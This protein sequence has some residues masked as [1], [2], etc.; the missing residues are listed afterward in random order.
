VDGVAKTSLAAAAMLRRFH[1][2]PGTDLA[3]GL[4][5]P[6]VASIAVNI[7]MVH[8]HS[9]VLLAEGHRERLTRTK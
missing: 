6:F 7:R 4:D 2:R 9:A 8:V 5:L 1:G 3:H